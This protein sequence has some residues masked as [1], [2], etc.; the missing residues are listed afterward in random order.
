MGKVT[1]DVVL[2]IPTLNIGGTENQ[3]LKIASQ[4]KQNGITTTIIASRTGAMKNQALSDGL[5]FIEISKNSLSKRSLRNGLMTISAVIRIR[6]KVLDCYL[7]ESVIYGLFVKLIL[8]H[9]IFFI[10]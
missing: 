2:L 3:I 6:P 1:S 8:R 5:S 10:V 7:P 9:K 4:C